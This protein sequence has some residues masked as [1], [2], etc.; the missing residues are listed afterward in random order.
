[1]RC[2]PAAVLVPILELSVIDDDDE[3]DDPSN[4]QECHHQTACGPL[5]AMA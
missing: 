3:D 5:D 4:I 2:S 1:M